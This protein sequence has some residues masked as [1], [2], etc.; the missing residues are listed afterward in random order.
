VTRVADRARMELPRRRDS[1]DD[2]TRVFASRGDGE[3]IAGARWRGG[4][5]VVD[6]RP[7]RF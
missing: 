4:E 3:Y 7:A 5:R 6:F 2:V 1:A